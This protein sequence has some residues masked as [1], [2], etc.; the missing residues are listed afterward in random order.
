[1]N[2]PEIIHFTILGIAMPWS[3]TRGSGKRRF[4]KKEEKKYRR[5]FLIQCLNY[6]PRELWTGPLRLACKFYVPIPKS[7]SKKKK[8]LCGQGL[9]FP[10]V[11]P[12]LSNYIKLVEDILNKQF[13]VDDAQVQNFNGSEKLY[14]D[15][16]ECRTEVWIEKILT[17]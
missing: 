17:H 1:M 3:R 13:W 14:D 10:I 11:V 2:K 7:F 15:G 8:D 16:K 9:L 5:D 4:I 12:D 6:R